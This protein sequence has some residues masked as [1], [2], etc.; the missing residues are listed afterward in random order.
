MENA[1]SL[2]FSTSILNYNQVFTWKNSYEYVKW[3]DEMINKW[4]W[5]VNETGF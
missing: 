5:E 4:K 2:I 3:F 1:V